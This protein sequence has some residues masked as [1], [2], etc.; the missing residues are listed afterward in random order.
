MA[1]L[2]GAVWGRNADGVPIGSEM[3]QSID[4]A[5]GLV[6]ILEDPATGLLLGA[7]ALGR[8]A[9]TTAYSYIA[10]TAPGHE[11]RGL[12]MLLKLQQRDWCLARGIT[13]MRWTFDPLVGRNGRFNLTKLGAT[14]S[15]Y[16]LEFYGVMSDQLNGNDPAD[17]L[18][19]EWNLIERPDGRAEPPAP[20]PEAT[21][22]RGPDGS[23]AYA[24]TAGARWIRVPADIVALRRTDPGQ[25]A[26]WRLAVRSWFTAAFADGFVGVGVTPHGWY[27]MKPQEESP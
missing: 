13:S 7:A 3:L 12:G 9:G 5:D 19:A 17:R 27:Y 15:R 14:A 25:S 16:D 20:A 6:T 26:A 8:G 11:Q 22:V 23:P 2:F 4:H 1:E 21:I 10:A 24:V 18:L